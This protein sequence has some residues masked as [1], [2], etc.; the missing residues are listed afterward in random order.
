MGTPY[1]R[2]STLTDG[3]TITAALFNDEYNQ[4]L[5]SFSYASSGTT[6]H[7]HDGTAGEGGNIAQIGD[8]DFLNKI[9]ADST[10]NRWR[11]FVQVDSGSVEQIRVQ[12]GAI[13]PVTNSDIDLGTSS[14]QFK[15]A[16]FDGTVEADALTINGTS[17][18][19]TIA[20]TV[21]AM[22]SSNT[23]TGIAVTYDDNDNTLD[24]VIGASVIVSSMIADGTIVTADIANNAVTG[25]KLSD[26]VTIAGDLVVTGDLTV[27]GDDIVMATNTIGN[28]LIADGTNFNSVAVSSLAEISTVA[29]DDVFLAIDTS[30]GG[31]KKISRSAI[32]SGLATSSAIANIV[33]DTTPQLGGDLDAQAK[34]IEGAG[35]VSAKGLAHSY[36]SSS[37]PTVFTVTVAS[38]TAGHPYNGDGSSSAYF[39]NGVEA[40]ALQLA[41]VDAITSSSGYYFKFDQAHSTNSGHPLR[42]YVD[43][44]KTVAYST[45]VTTSGTPGNAGAHTTI[46]VTSS[47]PNILYYQCSSH[48]YM[49]NHA[50]AVTTTLGTYGAVKI[51]SGTTAQR[52][53]AVAGQFRYNSTTG[54]FEGYSDA[55]GDIGGG[56]ATITLSTMTGDGSDT[57]LTL[58]AAPPSENALQVYFDGVYQHKD[59]FSFSG[60]TLT[61]STAPASGVKVEAINLLTVAASTTPADTSV[62]TAKLASNAVTTVKITDANVTTAKIADD[63]VTA[64]KLASNAVVTASIVDDNVTQ[65]KI[66]DN[67]VGADQLAADAVVTAS[68]V[69]D[70]VTT[71]KIADDAITSALIADNAVVAA[72]IADNAVDIARLNVSDGSAGQ[73]LTTDGSGTLSFATVGGLYN[74]WLVK[75]ANFTMASGDQII[76]N[77]ASTAFTLTLPSSPSAGAVVTVKNVGAALITIGRNS[78][79]INSAAGDALLPKNN[80]ATL[81][82]VDSTIGWTTI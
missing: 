37:S 43:A 30:G 79:N 28:L 6:G 21:G 14:L 63:A 46:A 42:F 20:D 16:Y 54:K 50:T 45:G 18:A 56:E 40:P 61:F 5:T 52:P 13:V 4:L 29:S 49:G 44:A 33:E 77:H 66:A 78:S 36:G 15:D 17:L 12:D 39:L 22:V 1:T 23:E 75:T 8:Q 73:S 76:G 51:P 41:G 3:D 82:F 57:T 68:M 55:W 71:A 27:S 64:A 81:V 31:L 53:T 59:T 48:A 47:T 65:A 74:D 60:T 70:A 32:V 80:A 19:E 58:S 11:F 69:D 25:D 7:Q 26:D 38:K 62:T 72:A 35:L 24:F 10:N 34:D 67:A 2:Q 9:V